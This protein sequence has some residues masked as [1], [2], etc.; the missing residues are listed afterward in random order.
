LHRGQGG[1]GLREGT[2]ANINPRGLLGDRDCLTGRPVATLTR[3]L[4]WL[5]TDRQLHQAADAHLL[6]IPEL[7]EHDR[8][9]RS[10]NTFGLSATDIGPVSDG[11]REL[12]LGARIEPLMATW[13]ARRRS[14]SARCIIAAT[15]TGYSPERTRRSRLVVNASGR[16]QRAVK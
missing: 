13:S 5:D 10:E 3:L 12:Y 1:L 14:R 4:G 16:A 2:R 9:E 15:V 6:G 7:L 8:L 11:V